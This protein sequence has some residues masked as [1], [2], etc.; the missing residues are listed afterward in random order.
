MSKLGKTDGAPG[1]PT[2]LCLTSGVK[3]RGPERSEGHVSFNFRVRQRVLTTPTGLVITHT[4]L[5]SE[6][7][8]TVTFGRALHLLRVPASLH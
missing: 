8:R 3:L 7:A 1:A 5:P 2:S 4:L 6:S